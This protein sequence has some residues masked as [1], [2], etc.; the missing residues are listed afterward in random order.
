[1][2]GADTGT[3]NR[4]TLGKNGHQCRIKD[5]AVRYV[6]PRRTPP[7]RETTSAG[8]IRQGGGPLFKSCGD[9]GDILVPAP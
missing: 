5:K 8:L 3:I 2:S 7:S 1:M 9:L 4:F 6:L